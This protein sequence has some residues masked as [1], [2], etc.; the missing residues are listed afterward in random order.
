MKKL[1][2]K[3]MMNEEQSIKNKKVILQLNKNLKSFINIIVDL[4]NQFEQN[5]NEIKENI[6]KIKYENIRKISIEQINNL[7]KKYSETNKEIDKRIE[8]LKNEMRDIKI[9]MNKNNIN[10]A[11]NIEDNNNYI[12]INNNKDSELR[13]DRNEE[14]NIFIKFENLLAIIIDKNNIDDKLK[15]ELNQYCEKLI[16][17]NISPLDYA[18]KYF[19]IACKYFQ[20]EIGKESF[21]KIGKAKIKILLTI[22]EI[23]KKINKKKKY[24]KYI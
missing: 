24:I 4:K 3:Q 11:C 13:I 15:E 17:N 23:E 18:S 9:N 6:N 5:F 7:E 14:Q 20:N 16:I 10:N 19:S 22:D 1:E 12:N 2:K 8:I 21:E